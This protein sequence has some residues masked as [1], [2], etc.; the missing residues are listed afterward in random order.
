MCV[1]TFPTPDS[2][3]MNGESTKRWYKVDTAAFERNLNYGICA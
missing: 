3:V 2:R 1:L